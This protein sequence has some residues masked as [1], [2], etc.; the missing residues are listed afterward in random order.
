GG[1][2]SGAGLPLCRCRLCAAIS[3]RRDPRHDVP[4]DHARPRTHVVAERQ[5]ARRAFRRSRGLRSR[6]AG[7]AR[8]VPQPLAGE[9]GGA[10]AAVIGGM[11]WGCRPSGFLPPSDLF[12]AAAADACPPPPNQIIYRPPPALFLPQWTFALVERPPRLLR[13]NG[14]EL[15]VV[16][17]GCLALLRLLHLEQ[18]HRVDLAPVD[19]HVALAH[20]PVLGRQ[21]LHLR[22]HRLAVG[23]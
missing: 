17:P 10:A 12:A 15:L 11:M 22:D 4:V 8:G 14:R 1:L 6:R 18:V 23:M 7:L 5:A 13:R 2:V 9:A 21:L 20:E 3:S 16:V 19:A